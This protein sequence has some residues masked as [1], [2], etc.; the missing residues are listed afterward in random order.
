MPKHGF[1]DD[2]RDGGRGGGADNSDYRSRQAFDREETSHRGRAGRQQA[3]YG[4]EEDSRGF[5]CGAAPAETKTY[6]GWGKGVL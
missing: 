4:A 2:E 5:N 1:T 6:G 3:A